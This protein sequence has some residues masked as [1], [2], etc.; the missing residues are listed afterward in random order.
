MRFEEAKFFEKATYPNLLAEYY[1]DGIGLGSL[2]SGAN[3]SQEIAIAVLRGEEDLTVYEKCS[4]ANYVFCSYDYL[5][6]P[7]LSVLSKKKHR[8]QEW[9]DRLHRELF[10]IW[11]YEKDGNKMAHEF[12]HSKVQSNLVRIWMWF[13]MTDDFSQFV[14]YAAYRSIRRETD[15]CLQK[16]TYKEPEPRTEKIR[17]PITCVELNTAGKSDNIITYF[18]KMA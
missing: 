13:N 10:V 5:F 1:A 11:E 12:M 2:M 7:R 3:I 6:S 4:L 18:K 14:T 15:Y 9:I 16:L 8:H 17:K